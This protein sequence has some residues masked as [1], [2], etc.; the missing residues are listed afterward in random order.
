M[1]EVH[2][3]SSEIWRSGTH[4]W[5][6]KYGAGTPST[7]H[8]IGNWASAWAAT[9]ELFA[10]ICK[11]FRVTLCRSPLKRAASRFLVSSPGGPPFNTNRPGNGKTVCSP[12]LIRIH[13]KPSKVPGAGADRNWESPRRLLLEMK[14]WIPPP[15]ISVNYGW[16]LVILSLLFEI[17][18]AKS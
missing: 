8:P 6:P 9:F 16:P 17:S 10:L 2:G 4:W 14:P 7:N 13:R 3:L 18:S 11:S 12:G 5:P 15:W 1:T